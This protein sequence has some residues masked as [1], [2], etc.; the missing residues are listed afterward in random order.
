M[1]DMQSLSEVAGEVK[2]LNQ[3][4]SKIN[5][6][7]KLLPEFLTEIKKLNNFLTEFGQAIKALAG[8]K[9]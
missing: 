6:N 7:A 5:D 9:N 8:K 4:L 1:F 2:K 3:E